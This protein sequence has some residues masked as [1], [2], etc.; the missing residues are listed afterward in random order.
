ML[1][2]EVKIAWD[3]E[4]IGWSYLQDF[5]YSKTLHLPLERSHWG[6]S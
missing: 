6:L 1:Q 2:E 4:Q 5:M 3:E